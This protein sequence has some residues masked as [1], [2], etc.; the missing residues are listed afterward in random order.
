V[1]YIYYII[2]RIPTG[3]KQV[4]CENAPPLAYMTSG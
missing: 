4:S 3:Q 1:H 2:S